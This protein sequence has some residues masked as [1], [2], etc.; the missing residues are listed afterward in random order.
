MLEVQQTVFI[1][2]FTEL[3]HTGNR[4]DH[5]KTSLDS[6]ELL[7]LHN[8]WNKARKSLI[9]EEYAHEHNDLIL[10]SYIYSTNG[11]IYHIKGSLNCALITYQASL[12]IEEQ[13][14]NSMLQASLLN[15]IGTV[16]TDM[17]YFSNG[18][19]IYTTD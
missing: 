5:I 18:L 14:G 13:S 8:E 15:S 10:L 16:Y 4:F 6:L 9:L 1:A 2:P 3:S 11:A 19:K 17:G 12:Q 7:I